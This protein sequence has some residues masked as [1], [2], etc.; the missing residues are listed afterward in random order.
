M[1][2]RSRQQTPPMAGKDETAE[3]G[4]PIHQLLHRGVAG[5]NP[6]QHHCQENGAIDAD[7]G[8]RGRGGSPAVAS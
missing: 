1:H 6:A 2:K 8:V 4:A 3:L 7:Q 5:G